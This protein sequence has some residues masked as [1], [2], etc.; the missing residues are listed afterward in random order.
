M[1][2]VLIYILVVGL[3]IGLIYWVVDQFPVP[4][5]A[6]KIIKVVAMVVGC[7]LIILALLSLTGYDAGLPGL[8][9][10]P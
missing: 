8:R 9:R 6:N 3:I 2:G 10:L 5:P 7:I 4:Q 1:I